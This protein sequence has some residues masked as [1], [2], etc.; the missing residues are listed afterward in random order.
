MQRRPSVRRMQGLI[1]CCC[2]L[3]ERSSYP[4]VIRR[5]RNS[6][7]VTCPGMSF[8]TNG[9]SADWVPGGSSDCSSR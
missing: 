8:A 9:L 2:V 1:Y 6:Q 7:C 4:G 5:V 3:R